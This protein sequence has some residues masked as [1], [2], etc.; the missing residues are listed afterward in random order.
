MPECPTCGRD[1]FKS[2]GGMKYHHATVHNES[3][4]LT[5][6]TCQ[7]C[8]GEYERYQSLNN[9]SEKNF[10]SKGC[11][12][13]WV[14]EHQPPEEAP[15]WDGGKE[16]V[17]CSICGESIKRSS[18]EI[19][20]RSNHFCSPECETEWRKERFSGESHPQFNSV[21]C[22][23]DYCGD[24]V[25]RNPSLLQESKKTFC[26]MECQ[27][28]WFSENIRGED[29][30]LWKSDSPCNYGPEWPQKRRSC[31]ERDDYECQDCGLTRDEHYEQYDC[32]LNIHHKTPFR[33]FE[34][35]SEANQLSNLITV[36]KTC[37][38]DREH[39]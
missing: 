1:D 17:D 12:S 25:I 21:T 22:E 26:S 32:D 16:D 34:D 20:E 8:G 6:Y 31:L 24:E 38:N 4:A 18:W 7:F 29:H 2:E 28:N 27:G 30:P 11:E 19:K 3:L 33:T 36:C 14:E 13:R 15:R 39:S 10:C 37:H 23:C 9:Q 35:R 5:T